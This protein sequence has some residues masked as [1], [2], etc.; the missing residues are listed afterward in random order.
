MDI[1]PLISESMRAIHSY[2]DGGF[3][4]SG[5]RVDGSVLLF[6][7][8]IHGWDITEFESLNDEKIKELIDKLLGVEIL[9]LGTGK[10]FAVLPTKMRETFLQHNISVDVM[11]TGAACRTYNVLM[12]EERPIAAAMIAV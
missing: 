12:S 3:T 6:P 10:E 5:E 8:E 1:T 11:D 9:L 4:I 2:G 7:T